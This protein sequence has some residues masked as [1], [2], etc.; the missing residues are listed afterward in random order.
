M[1]VRRTRRP[2][3]EIET[4]ENP[5]NYL[6]PS[7]LLREILFPEGLET[8][9]AVSS[10]TQRVIPPTVEWNEPTVGVFEE[11]LTCPVCSCLM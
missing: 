11:E 6:L 8:D 3:T 1:R 5:T 9:R 10:P 4:E 7:A 2:K